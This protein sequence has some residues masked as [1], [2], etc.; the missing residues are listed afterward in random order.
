MSVV[1]VGQHQTEVQQGAQMRPDF[2][3][4]NTQIQFP[5]SFA[6]VLIMVRP[7]DPL[8]VYAD[9]GAMIWINTRYTPGG[10][11]ALDMDTKCE[12]VDGCKRQ[13]AGE[14]CFMNEWSGAGV[15]A[16]SFKLPGDI[17]PFGVE[18]DCN[19]KLNSGSYICGSSN[20]KVTVAFAGCAA[21]CCGGE[22]PFFTWVG[23][24]DDPKYANQQQGIF[25]AGGYG[26]IVRHEIQAGEVCYLNQGL[27]FASNDTAT[28]AAE[29]CL[30][31]PIG[32]CYGNGH[33]FNGVPVLFTVMKF[34]G[35]AVVYAQNKNPRVW[36][37]LLRK[38]KGGKNT[39]AEEA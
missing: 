26:G 35:P 30:A 1:P 11:P 29:C 13:C 28:A 27:F 34:T 12:C 15:I 10:K 21:C 5:Q 23:L 31:G 16:F 37:A 32:C 14:A 20:L 17:L 36:E 25:W 24:R 7:E 6:Q 38:T 19:W 39:G 2:N 8:P 9:G 18:K 4:F 22:D 3:L 33:T